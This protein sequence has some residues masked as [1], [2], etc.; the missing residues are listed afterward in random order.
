M[1][2]APNILISVLQSYRIMIPYYQINYAYPIMKDRY[3]GNLDICL[4]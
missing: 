2:K 4:I 1:N 3:R